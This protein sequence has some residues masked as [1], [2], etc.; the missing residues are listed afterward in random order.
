MSGEDGGLPDSPA[1]AVRARRESRTPIPE[2]LR[3]AA[4]EHDSESE[5]YE[6]KA[7]AQGKKTQPGAGDALEDCTAALARPAPAIRR[8]AALSYAAAHHPPQ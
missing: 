4:R 5:G 8:R 3:E 7:L 2:R 1:A 6:R